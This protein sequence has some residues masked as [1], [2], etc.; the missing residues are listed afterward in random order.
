[1]G[2]LGPNPILTQRISVF[3]HAYRNFIYL[4]TYQE[5]YTTKK[6][7]QQ[8][9]ADTRLNLAFYAETQ[10]YICVTI[11]TI[12]VP[13]SSFLIHSLPIPH[14]RHSIEAKVKYPNVKWHGNYTAVRINHVAP[15]TH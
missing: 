2:L 6:Q 7:Q 5:G 12:S 9:T 4:C 15:N 10:K 13:T 3:R 14:T 1:M 11:L 8:N